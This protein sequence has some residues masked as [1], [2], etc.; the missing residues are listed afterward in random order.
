MW[1]RSST[2]ARK[3]K[4]AMETATALTRAVAVA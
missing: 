3:P 2:S 4:T 1:C